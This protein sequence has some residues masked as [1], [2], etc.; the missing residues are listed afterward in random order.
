MSTSSS[1]DPNA[2]AV[3]VTIVM[4]CLNEAETLAVCIRK[5][6]AAIAASGLQGEVVIAD[7]GSRD[8]SLEIAAAE[9]ARVI[10]VPVR[11]YG[12]ALIAGIESARGNYVLMADAD[13]SYEL[14]API[15][16]RDAHRASSAS[17][18]APRFPLST[19]QR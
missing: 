2:Q 14:K 19:L 3:A 11:G 16:S 5:A 4:P 8:G 10:S 18:F 17:L 12:A 6:L 13:D 1:A 15:S 7:N 9:G